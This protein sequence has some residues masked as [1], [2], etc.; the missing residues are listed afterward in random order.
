MQDADDDS[1]PSVT[2]AS[3]NSRRRNDHS[4]RNSGIDTSLLAAYKT[5]PPRAAQGSGAMSGP[6]KNRTATTHNAAASEKTWLPARPVIAK[7]VRDPDAET[8]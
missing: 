6:A 2:T 1:P 5:T 8:G 3:T 4:R 7:A